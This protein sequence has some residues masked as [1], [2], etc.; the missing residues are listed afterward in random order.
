MRRSLLVLGMASVLAGCATEANSESDAMSPVEERA[1]A[2]TLRAVMQDY[3]TAW[4]RVSCDNQDA[5]LRFFDWSGSGLIDASETTV[6]EYPGDAWPKLI[7]N[8]VCSNTG[9]KV[10]LGTVLVRVF[11]RDLASVSWTF[12]ASY[13]QKA[14]PPKLARGAVLQVFRRTAKGW[15]TPVGMSTHQPLASK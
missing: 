4:S 9:E 10:Q 8:A 3:A 12:Q 14:G 5:I 11:T 6:T 7:K 13:S 2:D 1:L 15:K